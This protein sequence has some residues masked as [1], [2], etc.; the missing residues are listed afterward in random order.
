V[1]A[2]NLR[3]ALMTM[4]SLVPLM[5]GRQASIVNVASGLGLV[6]LRT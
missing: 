1:I 5:Q 6:G 4:R 3:G 2:V